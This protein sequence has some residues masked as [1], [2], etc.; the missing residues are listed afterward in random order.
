MLPVRALS[1]AGAGIFITK[2]GEPL[3]IYVDPALTSALTITNLIKKHGGLVCPSPT[4]SQVLIISPV[5]TGIFDGHC[6]PL[7]LPLSQRLRHRRRVRAGGREKWKE[8]VIVQEEW[9]G[10]CVR[11]GRVLGAE[12][13]WGGYQKG[14]PPVTSSAPTTTSAIHP[15]VFDLSL[16]RKRSATLPG[17]RILG[18]TSSAAPTAEIAESPPDHN[19]SVSSSG[20]LSG[21]ASDPKTAPKRA[22]SVM[23]SGT[24]EAGPSTSLAVSPPMPQDEVF[25]KIRVQTPL[26]LDEMMGRAHPHGLKDGQDRITVHR[27]LGE[28]YP[29]SKKTWAKLYRSWRMQDGRFAQGRL[30]DGDYMK[31]ID[32]L[33]PLLPFIRQG[34]SVDDLATGLAIDSPSTTQSGWQV[35]IRAWLRTL[36]P[37][38]PVLQSEVR[39]RA[40]DK[41]R[42]EVSKIFKV[43]YDVPGINAEVVGAE[44]SDTFPY[45]PQAIAVYYRE[46]R[47]RAPRFRFIPHEFQS[48]IPIRPPQD[49]TDWLGSEDAAD[50]T[51]QRKAK[52]LVRSMSAAGSEIARDEGTEVVYLDFGSEEDENDY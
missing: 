50:S 33:D 40:A 48:T 42:L 15:A 31:H 36:P 12:D 21:T 29:Y 10:E 13:D 25:K 38:D 47:I 4:N 35:R 28:M 8:G 16:L 17:D 1:E 7:W 43:S 37:N 26:V 24:P 5:S 44:L 23:T 46:W 11:R 6:H 30:P 34:V 45:R 20:T 41:R 51:S 22:F 39:K 49:P 2:T 19:T 9:A 52:S 27:L 32:I 14:G 18:S 3:S